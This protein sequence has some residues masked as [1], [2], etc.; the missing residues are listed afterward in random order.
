MKLF[1]LV[2]RRLEKTTTLLLARFLARGGPAFCPARLAGQFPPPDRSPGLS[3]EDSAAWL[4]WVNCLAT[5]R[6]QTCYAPGQGRSHSRLLGFGTG[7]ASGP[8][9]RTRALR[10]PCALHRI[11]PALQALFMCLHTKDYGESHFCRMVVVARLSLL[12]KSGR[13]TIISLKKLTDD[14][15]WSRRRCLHLQTL[16]L[17][18]RLQGR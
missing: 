8:L 17:R 7:G 11:C 5:C 1:A 10:A 9:K 14:Q 3:N 2:V 18:L 13:N 15:R 4:Q 16:G 6:R 12:S